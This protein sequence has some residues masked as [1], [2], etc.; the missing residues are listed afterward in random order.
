MEVEMVLMEDDAL[1][2]ASVRHRTLERTIV[3]DRIL[4]RVGLHKG[5]AHLVRMV[6]DD[7]VHT[8][9]Y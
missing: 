5:G 6:Y 7:Y 1:F 9:L 8:G 4:I 3:V 2:L